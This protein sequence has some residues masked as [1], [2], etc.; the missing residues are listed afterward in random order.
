[1]INVTV[2]EEYKRRARDFAN[3]RDVSVPLKR[4]RITEEKARNDVYQG[5]LAEFAV[6]EILKDRGCTEPDINIY[7]NSSKRY[8]PDLKL[9]DGTRVHVKCQNEEQ[10]RKYGIS[11]IFENK[12]SG[13]HKVRKGIAALCVLNNDETVGIHKIVPI[14]YLHDNNLFK[15][16]K[17]KFKGKKAVY[18]KDL[19][20]HEASL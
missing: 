20:D 1:M 5:C 4:A 14:Q 18:A 8:T 15:D 13:V 2:S 12:D 11:W 17:L 19:V 7:E 10:G 9:A 16:T 3:K 6:Y